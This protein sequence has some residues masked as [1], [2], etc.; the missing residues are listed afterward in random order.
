MLCTHLKFDHVRRFEKTDE[1][2][3]KIRE[4]VRYIRGSPS[5]KE[6][7]IKCVTDLNLDANRGLKQDLPT[8]WNSTFL[9]L[10]NAL[11]FRTVFEHLELTDLN[12]KAC[13][14]TIEW[15]RAE[16]LCKFL[17]PFYVLTCLFSRTKYPISNLFSHHCWR[18]FGL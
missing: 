9:M 17:E 8:R 6:K 7:F 13:S 14:S 2:V 10:S 4:Y 12:F 18:Y 5:R 15:E 16:Q 11:Y 1:I 3:E